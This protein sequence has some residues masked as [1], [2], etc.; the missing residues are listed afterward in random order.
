MKAHRKF[1]HPRG[2]PVVGRHTGSS[3]I[4]GSDP[5][6][7]ILKKEGRGRLRLDAPDPLK[8]PQPHTPHVRSRLGRRAAFN[9]RHL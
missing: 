5:L 2:V 8:A 3:A 7:A 9:Q 4:P 6:M 1:T